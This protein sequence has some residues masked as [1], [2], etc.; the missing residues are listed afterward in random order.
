MGYG[1]LHMFS[2]GVYID[3]D[4]LYVWRLERVEH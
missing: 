3:G 1:F 2:D 4:L